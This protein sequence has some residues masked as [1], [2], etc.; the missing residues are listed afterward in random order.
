MKFFRIKIV[1]LIF[2][3]L[4][5]IGWVEASPDMTVHEK[6]NLEWKLWGYRP[7]VWRMNFDFRNY[8]EARTKS[9]E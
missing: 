3:T 9:S 4:A 1:A 5:Y 2:L 8:R 7:N 6:S